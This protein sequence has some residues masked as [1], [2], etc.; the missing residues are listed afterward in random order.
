MSVVIHLG[1]HKTATTFLQAHWA[2]C[3]RQPWA[4][5]V[6]APALDAVREALTPAVDGKAS[7]QLRSRASRWLTDLAASHHR[8]V[9]SDEN[10]IG[11]SLG[12]FQAKT[13]Y[14]RA[15][16]RLQQLGSLLPSGEL[17]VLLSLRG[18]ADY[19]SSAYCEVLRHTPFRPFRAR[20]AGLDVGKRG[21]VE[22]VRDV[23]AALPHARLVVWCYEDF[24]ALAP[25]LTGWMF[26]RP[27]ADLPS[28]PTQRYR[29]SF[30]QPAVEAATVV[31]RALGPEQ[32]TDLLPELA[33]AMPV[34]T[35]GAFSPWDAVERAALDRAYDSALET[36]AGLPGVAFWRAQPAPASGEGERRP[37]GPRPTG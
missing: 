22:L 32:A 19:L 26:D 24:A 10:L 8:L 12:N 17:T 5:A 16:E 28:A 7:S 14:P 27:V 29:A 1:V 2:V 34:S 3:A 4:T 6:S 9:I 35:H 18:Y 33:S 31:H 25:A 20:V 11:T 15:R 36:M 21:W 13:L 37:T 23:Q 30:S